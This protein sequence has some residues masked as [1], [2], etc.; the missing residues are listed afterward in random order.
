MQLSQSKFNSRVIEESML[1][2]ARMGSE[3]EG[4]ICHLIH[5]VPDNV[6]LALLLFVFLNTSS[7]LN[8][9]V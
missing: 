1:N 6:S 3:A 4:G 9:L 8:N 2:P 7:G 5:V